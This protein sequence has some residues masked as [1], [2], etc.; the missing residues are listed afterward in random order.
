MPLAVDFKIETDAKIFKAGNI[1]LKAF[2]GTAIL[3][4]L[5][6]SLWK[7][8]KKNILWAGCSRAASPVPPF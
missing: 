3:Q 6:F 7:E 5:L 2:A 1:N 8:T 4:A